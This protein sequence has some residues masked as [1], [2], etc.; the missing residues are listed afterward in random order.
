VEFSQ[1][2][3]WACDYNYSQYGNLLVLLKSNVMA[4]AISLNRHL[5]LGVTVHEVSRL[6]RKVIDQIVRPM[7][8]TG[9]QWW[10]LTYISLRP[11]LS[12][13]RLSEELS[14][15]KVALGSLVERLTKNKLVER[16][17][18]PGDKR[19]NLL[20]LTPAG[21]DFTLEIRRLAAGV[22]DEALKNIS[23][24][25]LDIAISVLSRMKENLERI[26]GSSAADRAS[27]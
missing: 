27:F 9:T 16:R 17:S 5:K 21:V 19:A 25:D 2:D 3:D 15:G 4:S 26:Y 18:D 10:V 6:R 23:P 8:I 22:Q 20:F 13:V 12:Q 24:E 11:G 7:D 14:L 1:Q